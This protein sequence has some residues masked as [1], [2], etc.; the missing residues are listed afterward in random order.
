MVGDYVAAVP[1]VGSSPQNGV[2]PNH[3]YIYPPGTLRLKALRLS[4]CI[5]D[6]RLSGL[7]EV[8][9]VTCRLLPIKRTFSPSFCIDSPGVRI[10]RF[11][12]FAISPRRMKWRQFNR[13]DEL[14]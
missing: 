6:P 5:P 11:V 3:L 7:T 14:S 10:R 1:A 13:G 12:P 2:Q 9:V 8:S 4:V